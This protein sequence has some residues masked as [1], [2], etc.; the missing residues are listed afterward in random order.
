MLTGLVDTV[1]CYPAPMGSAFVGGETETPAAIAADGTVIVAS[2]DLS[3]K[4]F[5]PATG[6][7]AWSIPTTAVVRGLFAIDGAGTLYFGSEDM[8][9]TAASVADGSVK[10]RFGVPAAP[11]AISVAYNTLYAGAWPP[12]RCRV[13]GDVAR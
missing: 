10:W 4:G 2:S 11:E 12:V 13:V 3:I 1:T 6:S 7:V 9:L 8:Y 5:N